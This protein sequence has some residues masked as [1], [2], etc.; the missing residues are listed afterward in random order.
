VLLKT[1]IGCHILLLHAP[2]QGFV[3]LIIP[4]IGKAHVLLLNTGRYQFGKKIISG[5]ESEKSDTSILRHANKPMP[6]WPSIHLFRTAYYA[7]KLGL[8][9]LTLVITSI[10]DEQQAGN[11]FKT[12]RIKGQF[13]GSLA[14][15]EQQP[16]GYDWHVVKTTQI[17]GNFD[18]FCSIR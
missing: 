4:F 12:K 1:Q 16:G 8:K 2:M 18:M 11:P 3:H 5:Y 15:V 17:D 6:R 7:P 9:P 10:T 13:S 14:D